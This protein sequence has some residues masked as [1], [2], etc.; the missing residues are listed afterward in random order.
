MRVRENIEIALMCV[1]SLWA[2]YLLGLILPVHLQNYGIRPRTV[3]GL[4]GL[5]AS[6]FLHEGLGHLLSNSI[7]L[8]PLLSI[9]LMYSRT[10]TLETVIFSALVGGGFVWLFGGANTV[11]IGASGVIFGLIGCMLAIGIFRRE[12]PALLVSL[13]VFSYYGYSLFSL[14]LVLPGVSWTGHFFGF[15]SGVLAAWLAGKDPTS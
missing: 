5:I 13:L 2:V 6:P 3:G 12:A 4:F 7:A 10:L 11:H 14:L 15:A 1:A 8:A 9:S